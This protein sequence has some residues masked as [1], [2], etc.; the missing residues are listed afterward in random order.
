M[1]HI[2]SDAFLEVVCRLSPQKPWVSGSGCLTFGR[3]RNW[4]RVRGCG[5]T[6][7]SVE[8]PAFVSEGKES[9]K[10][11]MATPRSTSAA[12]EEEA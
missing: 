6:D 8:F 12:R 10:P 2:W 5:E 1:M 3:S 9:P 7:D 11:F 4:D